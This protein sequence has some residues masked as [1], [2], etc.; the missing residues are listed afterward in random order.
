V[1]TTTTTVPTTTTST[2]PE[3]TYESPECTLLE[4]MA[5]FASDYADMGAAGL[6]DAARDLGEALRAVGVTEID[7][8]G[9]TTAAS[10]SNWLFDHVKTTILYKDDSLD[11][12]Q[13]L[14]CADIADTAIVVDADPNSDSFVLDSFAQIYAWR[15]NL[16]GKQLSEAEAAALESELDP[17]G[18]GIYY[19]HVGSGDSEDFLVPPMSRVTYTGTGETCAFDLVASASGDKLDFVSGLG[20]GGFVRMNLSI[21]GPTEVFVSDVIGCRGGELQFG[22]NP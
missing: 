15:Y 8:E 21:S 13:A 4:A 1:P 20:G 3:L 2:I 22:P 14:F 7:T 10:M 17:D 19:T 12:D 5:W 18:D 11:F 6:S 9:V 16:P